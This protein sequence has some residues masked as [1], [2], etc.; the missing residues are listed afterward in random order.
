MLRVPGVGVDEEGVA[1]SMGQDLTVD[2]PPPWMDD[3]IPATSVNPRTFHER[4]MN[5]SRSHYFVPPQ[6][7]TL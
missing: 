5:Y 2:H 4:L 1:I 3:D 7:S 6:H